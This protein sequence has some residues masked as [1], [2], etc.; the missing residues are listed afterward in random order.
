M[1]SVVVN[2]K[3][4][5]SVT[6]DVN[7]GRV[8]GTGS[9]A[10]NFPDSIQEMANQAGLTTMAHTL[11]SESQEFDQQL[12]QN[13]QQPVN[14][15]SNEPEDFAFGEDD[16]SSYEKT[17]PNSHPGGNSPG[18]RRKKIAKKRSRSQDRFEDMAL[19]VST[20]AQ[21]RD[22][23]LI[24][25]NINKHKADEL[26]RAYLELQTN[27]YQSKIEEANNIMFSAR[28]DGD[29]D[30]EKQALDVVGELRFDQIEKKRQLDALERK[31]HQEENK[32]PDPREAALYEHFDTKELESSALDPWLQ[33]NPECNPYSP[34]YDDDYAKEV[35]SVKKQLNKWLVG[36]KRK[37]IVGN[38]EYYEIL[39]DALNTHFGRTAPVS[40]EQNPYPQQGVAPQNYTNYGNPTPQQQR[41]AP[42][43]PPI[44]YQQPQQQPQYGYPPQQPQYQQPQNPYGYPPQQQQQQQYQQPQQQP[45]YGM[46]QGQKPLNTVYVPIGADP[47]SPVSRVNRDGYGNG[48]QQHAG[49]PDLDPLQRHMALTMPVFTKEGQAITDPAAKIHNYKMELARM[50]GKG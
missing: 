40:R 38:D 18:E 13:E 22:Q 6:Y 35:T 27:L 11:N 36:Q 21:E 47:Y 26:E 31:K 14:D 3:A 46:P 29:M 12:R 7:S 42:P 32:R 17:D 41:M 48:Q 5:S 49:L 37:G 43:P 30:L 19:R 28:Q 15:N 8:V 2:N 9:D 34:E 1:V 16:A 4:N 33:N 10:Y 24:E 39:D 44:Q 20:T 25:A 45:Q 23:A 50:N